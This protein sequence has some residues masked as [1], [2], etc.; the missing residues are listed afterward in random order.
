[1]AHQREGLA[2]PVGQAP[3]A[4]AALLVFAYKR[5]HPGNRAAHHVDPAVEIHADLL[6][7]FGKQRHALRR[8]VLDRTAGVALRVPVV[9]TDF[10][11]EPLRLGGVAEVGVIEVMGVPVHQ[12]GAEVEDDIIY[13][14]SR[15]SS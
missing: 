4:V 9:R 10:R 11:Q 5:L 1:M 12:D 8:D 14:R 6:F 3:D 15:S 7:P 13:H 2:G